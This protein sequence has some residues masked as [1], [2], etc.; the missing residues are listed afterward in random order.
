LVGRRCR[1]AVAGAVVETWPLEDY[2]ARRPGCSPPA[3]PLIRTAKAI[4][5]DPK[6]SAR[7][8]LID[9]P[10]GS[11]TSSDLGN[12]YAGR[13]GIELRR[14][15]SDLSTACTLLAATRGTRYAS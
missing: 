1:A 5:G 14:H 6:V 12:V 2:R 15:S 8:R 13:A 9:L 11:Q 7:L 3:T 4:P 10:A